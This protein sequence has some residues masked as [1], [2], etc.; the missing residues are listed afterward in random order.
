MS[1]VSLECS[2]AVIVRV[3]D[4]VHFTR[5]WQEAQKLMSMDLPAKSLPT[6]SN[7][8]SPG[9][10]CRMLD[11][12]G[13]RYGFYHLHVKFPQT[14]LDSHSSWV[15]LH[16]ALWEV[17]VDIAVWSTCMSEAQLMSSSVSLGTWC[18]QI[19]VIFNGEDEYWK[20][21]GMQLWPSLFWIF[22]LLVLC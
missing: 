11:T 4:L 13:S 22:S 8:G 17:L 10:L 5:Q 21:A 12:E 15:H 7:I 20:A 16:E 1:H 6:V 14:N 3:I 2:S 18:L 9:L 19:F